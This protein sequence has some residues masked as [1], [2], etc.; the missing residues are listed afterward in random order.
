MSVGN[1]RR[2]IGGVSA[3]AVAAGF[4]V[5]AGVGMAGAAPSSVSW[6]DGNSNFTRTVSNTTPVEGEIVTTSMKFMRKALTVVEYVQAVKDFHPACMTYVDGSAKVDGSPRGL[7]SQGADFVRVTGDW[8]V[9]PNIEPKSR[10]FEFSYKVGANC[11]RDVAMNTWTDY[12]GSLG[13]G[14]YPNKGTTV[15]VSK[16]VTTTVLAAVPAG[17]RVGQSVPLSATVTGGVDGN[18]VE[19]FD[20]TTKLGQGPLAAGKAAFAWT[21]AA[22]GGHSLT[23]KFLGTAKANESVSAAQNVPVTPAD[24]VTTT[25]VTGPA[26]AVAG[27]DVTLNVQVSPAPSGGTVQFKDGATNL[28]GP[29]TLGADGKG[30]ITQQFASGARSVTAV[31]SGAGEFLTS[32]SAAHTVAV[33]PA[34]VATTTVVSGPAT[35]VEGTDVTFDVQV[36]PAPVGGTVQF[37]DGAADLG[38]PVSLDAA[39]KGSITQQFAAGARSVTAVYSGAGEFLT[40]TSGAHSVTVSPAA[41]AD[42]ATTT[43]VSGAATAQ[44]GTPVALSAKVS[45]TPTGGTVQFKDGTTN[46]GN[47]VTVGADGKAA[48]SASFATSGAHEITAVFSGATGFIASTSAA[49]IVTVS[50][51]APT[52]V[53]TATTLTGP[54][55]ASTGVAVTYEAKVAPAPTGGTV[56]FFDGDTAVGDAVTVG[57]DGKVSLT[58]TFAVAGTST[59][60]AVYGGTNGYVGSSSAV[61]TVTV[62]GETPVDPGTGGGTGSLGALFGSS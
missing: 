49:H 58:H 4:A 55:T 37:K 5:T 50:A 19:F 30:S 34:D 60:K 62:T 38:A 11:D 16:N 25:A 21:P 43:T 24:V 32:T 17:V 47:P 20:G 15:T 61:V 7:E 46:I 29:V 35:A 42:L 53:Q 18:V 9:Y 22:A 45:P 14:S 1:T 33:S 6:A 26:T 13:S 56:Q 51:P 41:P 36:S 12:S 52:D 28:G 40:S 3:F 23:A 57:A 10:T 44:T 54:V 8:S 2:V 31:Y 27:A 59:L 39:G 48:T